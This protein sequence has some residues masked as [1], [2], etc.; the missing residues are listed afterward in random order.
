MSGAKPTTVDICI[1]TFRRAHLR[2]TLESIARLDRAPGIEMRVIVADNDEAPSALPLIEAMADDFPLPILYVHAPARNISIARNACLDAATGDYVAFVD[3]DETVSQQWLRELLR[4]AV[5]RDADAVLGPVD[6]SYLDGAPDWMRRGRFHSTEPVVVGG[7]IRTGYTCNVLVRRE[8]AASGLRFN[9]ARGRTG[10]ED[11]EYFS[12]L[13]RRGGLIVGA[14]KAMAFEVVPAARATMGWLVARRVRMGRT[15]GMLLIEQGTPRWGVAAVAA[16]KAG[17][18][19]ALTAASALSPVRWRQ[20]L[21]RGMLHVGVAGSAFG[22]SEQVQYGGA[23]RAP[24]S[25]EG[26]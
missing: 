22:L 12:A 10:G 15:H 3:D 9:L 2:V 7:A 23:D 17:Y 26:G 5:L 21:L 19:F 16:A 24:S 6:A 4:A 11:T 13:C 8:G 20:N 1:C 18:C 25:V 14:P